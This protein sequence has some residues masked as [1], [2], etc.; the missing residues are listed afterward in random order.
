MRN[1]PYFEPELGALLQRGSEQGLIPVRRERFESTI[2][3]ARKADLRCKRM[4]NAFRP[5]ELL[6][7]EQCVHASRLAEKLLDISQELEQQS[8]THNYAPSSRHLARGLLV[9]DYSGFVRA[10]DALFNGCEYSCEYAVVTIDVCDFYPSITPASIRKLGAEL[11]LDNALDEM[12]EFVKAFRCGLPINLPFSDLLAHLFLIPLERWLQ[13]CGFRYVRF[14][15]DF[16]FIASSTGSEI[17][18]AVSVEQILNKFDLRSNP[19]K[20]WAYELD[21]GDAMQLLSSGVRAFDSPIWWKKGVKNIEGMYGPS[22]I[23]RKGLDTETLLDKAYRPG[24]PVQSHDIDREV[25]NDGLIILANHELRHYYLSIPKCRP[26]LAPTLATCLTN[27]DADEAVAAFLPKDVIT[28]CHC[29]RVT[30]SASLRDRYA[31][32]LAKL[33]P[34]NRAERLATARL[35]HDVLSANE[36]CAMFLQNSDQSGV[37]VDDIAYAAYSCSMRDGL[38]RRKLRLALELTPDGSAWLELAS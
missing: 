9:N 24:Y 25:A 16:V 2:S 21:Q 7:A 12:A 38:D 35:R 14:K 8:P 19:Q 10:H 33:K 27:S 17:E 32:H 13:R 5:Y 6:P 1:A 31:E 36:I 22:V 28:T 29:M 26:H 4:H 23:V 20:F 34:T 11:N 30:Q 37:W 15:D 3:H 18:F